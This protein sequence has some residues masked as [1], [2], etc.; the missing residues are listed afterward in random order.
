[1]RPERRAR[2]LL[3]A[4][5]LAF[6]AESLAFAL[7]GRSIV[8]EG[9]YLSAAQLVV[10]GQRP[11]VDFPFLQGPTF[12]Y[13]YGWLTAPFGGS[14]LAGRVLSWLG[15]LV[16]GAAGA[17]FAFRFGGA[18]AAALALLL[19]MGN[20]PL[21]WLS[22][23]V[24]IQALSTPLVLVAA[25]ALARPARS[26]L[27]WAAAP[28]LLLWSTG[29][30]L[31]NG[32]ALAVVCVWIAWQLRGEP[33]RLAR[34]ALLVA[35]Q[36][37]VAFAPVWRAPGDAAFHVASA[38]LGRAQRLGVEPVTFA[39]KLGFYFQAD[40]G[41]LPFA[42]L[43]L[44]LALACARDLLG[45]RRP[46]LALPL[47]D[48][49]AAQAAALALGFLLLAPHFALDR[50]TLAYFVPT[51]ALVGTGAAIALARL[52]RSR[53]RIGWLA[54]A[55]G[56]AALGADAAA[57]RDAFVGS[58]ETGF[59]ALRRFGGELRALAGPDCRIATLQTQLAVAAGCRILPGLENSVYSY[60]P[61]L[62]DAEAEARRVLNPALLDRRVA[63]LRPALLAFAPGEIARLERWRGVPPS[64][65]R[66]AALGFLPAAGADYLL[67]DR[68][69][70][71]SG[72][73]PPGQPD[74]VVL[75]VFVRRDLA[76]R[77]AP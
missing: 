41:L 68:R 55:A 70:I 32:L 63:E 13:V 18:R 1:V 51:T 30:R 33:R 16:T 25:T 36:A 59:A 34:V 12:P 64:D 39:G 40:H 69:R 62:S 29:V 8:D 11:Y 6:A 72:V 4:L 9:V 48:A 44:L 15:C 19:A 77:P 49:A 76:D 57:R 37:L 61:A 24:R 31:T 35:A 38:Q 5:F 27:G 65:P 10:E 45:A 46:S 67:Y 71:A 53:P 66:S 60:F 42:G 47:R 3:A 21:L 14:L 73:R 7:T 22:T 2:A 56:L 58:G 17:W 28:S 52:S 50:P 20:L 23:T 74:G 54:I 43:G 75:L 26:A